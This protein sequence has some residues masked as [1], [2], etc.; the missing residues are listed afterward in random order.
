MKR[1]KITTLCLALMGTLLVP[2]YVYADTKAEIEAAQQQKADME[3]RMEQVEARISE[4]QALRSDAQA[5]IVAMDA[6]LA[7]V[8]ENIAALGEKK[9]EKENEI[10]TTQLELEA[11]IADEEEQ[12]ESMKLRIQF[13]YENGNQSYLDALLSSQSIADLLNKADYVAQITAYDRDM[14][15][16]YVDTRE[17]V[18]DKK[19]Q[20]I[21]ENEELSVLIHNAEVEAQSYEQLIAAKAEVVAEYEMQIADGVSEVSGMQQALNDFE[22]EI[23]ALEEKLRREQATRVYDGGQFTF[24]MAWYYRVTSPFGYRIHP[25]FGYGHGHTGIDLSADTGTEIYAA[26][27]GEVVISTYSSSA[28][29][30]IAINHGKDSN[31]NILIT[32]YLH[33][34][35]LYVSEGETVSA[36]QVIGLVGS[37]G[38]STGPHLHFTVKL[39]GEYVDPAPYI[40]LQ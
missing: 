40:G 23:A 35:K 32:M 9:V 12:Y 24:P 5:Y 31:G 33:C 4:L 34:S 27:A 8:E 30:Y 17:L 29:N 36:G 16:K 39:N 38:N 22:A 1:W 15:D 7:A 13:M 19:A 26:Y 3:E 21:T 11:A 20:L 18:E 28:G 10:A 37:T 6:E 2:A 25:I 14:L